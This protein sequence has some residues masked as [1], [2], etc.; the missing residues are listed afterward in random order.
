MVFEFPEWEL[1]FEQVLFSTH[2]TE[3]EIVEYQFLAS[4]TFTTCATLTTKNQKYFLKWHETGPE[5]LLAKEAENL[6]YLKSKGLIVPEVLGYG[7]SEGK[8]YLLL[9]Y[10][11]AQ[12]GNVSYLQLAVQLQQLHSVKH[13]QHGFGSNNY[14]WGV[15][16]SNIWYNNGPLFFA[17]QRLLNLAGE[18]MM[19]EKLDLAS[20]KRIE[21][22]CL[23]IEELLP[24]EPASL[25]HGNMNTQHLMEHKTNQLYFLSP[26][27]YYG[28]REAELAQMLLWGGFD[29]Q[30]VF[31]YNA[32]EGAIKLEPHFDKRLKVYN[33]YPLLV[34]INQGMENYI[35][36]LHNN[37]KTLGF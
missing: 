13:H 26:S 1:F 36:A 8:E 11:N 28:L 12:T 5:N 34:M 31:V 29:T 25:L 37:L 15:P 10:L 3:Q 30:F 18:A 21:Q 32:V 24:N 2:G 14:L 23:K 9:N 33:L 16:Q 4:G 35:I 6:N 20:F 17:E 22:C 19:A 7:C 27:C